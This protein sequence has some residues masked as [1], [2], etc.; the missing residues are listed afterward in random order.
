MQEKPSSQFQFFSDGQ[1]I[2][3]VDKFYSQTLNFSLPFP[4]SVEVNVAVVVVVNV[5]EFDVVVVLEVVVAV[6]E[7]DFVVALEVDV[8]L[9]VGAL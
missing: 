9:V 5:V 6:L 1:K 2:D 8:V 3:A 4:A 7:V